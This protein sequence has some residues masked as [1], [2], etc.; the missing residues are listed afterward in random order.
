MKFDR[1][2]NENFMMYA[3]QAYDNPLCKGIHEFNDDLTRIKYIKR[4]LNRYDKSKDLKER[5]ILNHI[6]LL[7][8]LTLS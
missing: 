2:N 4:L 7:D 3:M 1:L 8:P 5:L 6:I